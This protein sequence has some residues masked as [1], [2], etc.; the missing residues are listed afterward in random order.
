MFFLVVLKMFKRSP[1]A[2]PLF[3]YKLSFIISLYDLPHFPPSYSS[4]PPADLISQVP[5][6]GPDSQFFL[7]GAVD[8]IGDDMSSYNSLSC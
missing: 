3:S 8:A 2:F 5:K 4:H 6:P 7:V 1:L